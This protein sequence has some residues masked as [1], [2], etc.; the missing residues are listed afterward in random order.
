M[1]D[2]SPAVAATEV[3]SDPLPASTAA[4]VSLVWPV[5]LVEW[6][7]IDSLFLSFPSTEVRI[8][9]ISLRPSPPSP[10]PVCYSVFAEKASG[11]VCPYAYGACFR[12]EDGGSVEEA[13]RAEQCNASPLVSNRA[14]DS[15]LP[16]GDEG[17]CSAWRRVKR[18]RAKRG[19]VAL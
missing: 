16:V 7:L 4:K 5:F 9:T 10:S 8:H 11:S 2:S 19:A 14:G 3:V 18:G 17:T 12:A 6:F 15:A 1:A 13:R